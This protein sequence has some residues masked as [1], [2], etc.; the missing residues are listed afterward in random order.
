MDTFETEARP[1]SKGIGT[2]FANVSQQPHQNV[3]ESGHGFP[4]WADFCR[5]IVGVELEL[6]TV[7]PSH[8]RKAATGLEFRS[9]A[10]SFAPTFPQ[11]LWRIDNF[12][13]SV[14]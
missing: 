8:Y 12:R 2:S 13:E 7:I 4:L 14:L 3:L 1:S 9:G 10:P 6:E 11:E 5:H